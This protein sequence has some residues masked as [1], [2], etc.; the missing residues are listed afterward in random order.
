MCQPT[1][2]VALATELVVYIP[3]HFQGVLYSDKVA[4]QAEEAVFFLYLC[5]GISVPHAS[6]EVHLS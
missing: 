5:A 1:S 6:L 3:N 4:A 2:S